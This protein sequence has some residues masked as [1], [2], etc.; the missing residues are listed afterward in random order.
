MRNATSIPRKSFLGVNDRLVLR[1]VT[2]ASGELCIV[3]LFRETLIVD[4]DQFSQSRRTARFEIPS[5]DKRAPLAFGNQEPRALEFIK[6][7]LHGIE[8][9]AKIRG[10]RPAVGFSVMKQVQHGRLRRA[11]SQNLRKCSQFHDLNSRSH[12][13]I[14]KSIIRHP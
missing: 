13:L 1:P 12:D 5:V 4:R 14:F 6:L 9:D 11:A 7:L 3:D 10:N 2:A 8:R